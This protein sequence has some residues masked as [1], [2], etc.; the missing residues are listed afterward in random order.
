MRAKRVIICPRLGIPVRPIDCL[1][2]ENP[3][4]PRNFLYSLLD[5]VN[6]VEELEEEGINVIGVSEVTDCIRRAYWRR[7]EPLEPLTWDALVR[8]MIG[9]A[10]HQRQARL[11]GQAYHGGHL[12]GVARQHHRLGGGHGPGRGGVVAVEQKILVG[13]EHVFLAD[14]GTQLLDQRP[15]H[16]PPGPGPGHLRSAGAAGSAEGA[17]GDGGCRFRPG[18]GHLLGAGSEQYEPIPQRDGVLHS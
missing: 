2:C 11:V 8:I 12:F 9:S 14:E 3:C 10:G 4:A 5:Y 15:V 6:F 16:L 18:G 1:K 7:V 17:W 13:V